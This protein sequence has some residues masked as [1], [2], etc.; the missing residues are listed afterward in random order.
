MELPKFTVEYSDGTSFTGESLIGDWNKVDKPIHSM[1]FTFGGISVFLESFR[2]YNHLVERI[3]VVGAGSTAVTKFFIMGRL[4]KTCHIYEFDLKARKS[5]R[6][7]SQIG[8][9][10]NGQVITGWKDGVAEGQP[11]FKHG[12]F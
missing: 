5:L 9:E 10:Y 1:K 8:Q 2:S 11:K 7:V 3:A 12:K 6:K 4:E